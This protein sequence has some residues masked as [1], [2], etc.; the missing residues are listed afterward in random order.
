[1]SS[2]RESLWLG[3]RSKTCCYTAVVIPTGFDVWRIARALDAPPASFLIY[4]QTPV[5]RWDGFALDHSARRFRLALGKNSR[6]RRRGQPACGFLLRTR[7]GEHRCGLGDLRPSGCRVFPC[8]LR[9]GLVGVQEGHGC[10]CRSWSLA[11]VDTAVER[12]KLEARQREAVEYGRMVEAWNASVAST[13]EPTKGLD[14]YS[15]FLL[16]WYDRRAAGQ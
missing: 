3:C 5:P 15:G 8:E 1:M 9:D 4:F 7:T 6:L 2:L 10:T 13:P 16:D 12:P 11:D 14:E